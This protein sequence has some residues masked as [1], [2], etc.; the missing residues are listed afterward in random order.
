VY[1]SIGSGIENMPVYKNEGKKAGKA[2]V[3]NRDGDRRQEVVSA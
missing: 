2:M 1:K 3:F